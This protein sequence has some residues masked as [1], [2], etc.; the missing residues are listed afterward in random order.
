M[1][2]TAGLL[3]GQLH[4][5]VEIP[6]GNIQDNVTYPWGQSYIGLEGVVTLKHVWSREP[7]QHSV[8]SYVKGVTHLPRAL[9]PRTSIG[10]KPSRTVKVGGDFANLSDITG[11]QLIT[12]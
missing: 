1:N 2:G 7:L 10:T 11:W 6:R 12:F 5:R 4:A 9:G 8:D 3:R